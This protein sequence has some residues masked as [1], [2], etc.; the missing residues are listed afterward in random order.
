MV[1]QTIISNL[2][3]SCVAFGLTK[4]D[5]STPLFLA[6]SGFMISDD[7]FFVSAGHVSKAIFAKA[8]EFKA[9]K[10]TVDVRIFLNNPTETGVELV[11]FKV[12]LG[13][14]IPKIELTR[15]SETITVDADLYVGRV[16]GNDTFS[17]L[18]FDEPTKIKVFDSVLMCG[19]PMITQSL[20]IDSEDGIRWS[21]VLQSGIVSS[22]LPVDE[23]LNPY[24]LQTDI[25]GTGGSSGSP[26]INADT[27]VVLGI[28]QK[29]LLAEIT[30]TSNKAR[31]GLTYGVSNF[32]VADAIKDIISHI[33]K[34]IDKNGKPKSTIAPNTPVSITTD[35]YHPSNVYEK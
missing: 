23:S 25:V 28:A 22:L 26:I 13:Y 16:Q 11:A 5:S 27:G 6:G 33:K 14:E 2:K 12:G 8:E 29:V 31:I 4:K 30:G 15:D 32:F 3:K 20:V 24:G 18:T 17:F 9:N 10:I 35:N 7:G 19:Y 21:P 34:D 1:T